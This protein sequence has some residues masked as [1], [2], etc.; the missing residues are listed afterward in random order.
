[1]DFGDEA[2]LRPYQSDGLHVTDKPIHAALGVINAHL[3]LWPPNSHQYQAQMGE[4]R[5][6]SIATGALSTISI[7]RFCAPL[8]VSLLVRNDT[9]LE[10]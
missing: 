2:H 7:P 9:Q 10:D 4:S 5:H 8:S 1:M 3:E 6:P